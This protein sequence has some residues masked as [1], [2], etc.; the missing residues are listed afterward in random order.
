MKVKGETGSQHTGHARREKM[1]Y[2]LEQY[3]IKGVLQDDDYLVTLNGKKIGEWVGGIFY[4][5]SD[6]RG[7]PVTLMKF[8]LEKYPYKF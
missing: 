1:K 8:L 4:P 2:K 3:S 5:E 7:I 6:Y